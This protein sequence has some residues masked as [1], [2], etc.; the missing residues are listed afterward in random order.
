MQEGKNA[1]LSNSNELNYI[2]ERMS[3]IGMQ[4]EINLSFGIDV[5]YY[6]S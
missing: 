6:C 5:Y 4:T 3:E 1:R 2:F